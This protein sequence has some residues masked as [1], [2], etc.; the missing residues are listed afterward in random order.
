MCEYDRYYSAF[1][2]YYSNILTLALVECIVRI[3][4]PFPA[5]VCDCER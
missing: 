2:T 4:S 1:Y 5:V 3:C